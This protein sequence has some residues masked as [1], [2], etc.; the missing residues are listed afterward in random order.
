MLDNTMRKQTQIT[1]IRHEPSYK[2]LEYKRTEHRFY[3]EIVTNITTRNSEL[4]DTIGQH[5]KKT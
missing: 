1:L 4:K 5:E 3:A 2:Q